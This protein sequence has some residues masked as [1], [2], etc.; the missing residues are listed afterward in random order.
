[1]EFA[2]DE[3]RERLSGAVTAAIDPQGTAGT[4]EAATRPLDR[5]RWE[6]FARGPGA[7][8]MA[9]VS[10]DAITSA[11]SVA[12]ILEA[13]GHAGGPDTACL[14]FGCQLAG[15]LHPL[16]RGGSATSPDGWLGRLVA[17]EAFGAPVVPARPGEGVTVARA[18]GGFVISGRA[19]VASFGVQPDVLVVPVTTGEDDG[20]TS[21][22]LSL[23]A[24]P[25]PELDW[26]PAT[27]DCLA[28]DGVAFRGFAVTQDRM[29]S[30]GGS[31]G[32]GA[33]H[34]QAVFCLGIHAMRIGLLRRLGDVALGAARTA[35]R[36][37]KLTGHPPARFQA[38]THPIADFIVRCD[39][40]RL[41][42]HEG[43]RRLDEGERVPIE[44]LLAAFNMDTALLPYAAEVVGLQRHWGLAA[45]EDWGC[46]LAATTAVGR[47]AWSPAELSERVCTS[48]RGRPRPW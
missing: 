16:V 2:F 23:P 44:A 37:M 39:A 17:G 3:Q 1:V 19:S 21:A 7:A 10:T 26:Q 11:S 36:R 6:G 42:V 14:A 13:L 45:G 27:R 41:L 47:Y 24:E 43:A 34:A 29:L 31:G 35:A 40:A 12:A 4:G 46:L 5:H 15:V 22:L 38:L 18:E 9:E 8:A 30:A 48:L 20:G 33:A 25:C 32:D 28:P